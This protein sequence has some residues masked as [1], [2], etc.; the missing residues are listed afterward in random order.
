[1]TAVPP[2]SESQRGTP[3]GAGDF[4]LDPPAPPPGTLLRPLADELLAGAV[5]EES[6]TS[7]GYGALLRSRL[8]LLIWAAQLLSQSAQNVVNYALVV[9]VERLTQ[10]SASVGAVV[11]AFSLPVLLLGPSAGV[12]VD[13]VGKRGVLLWTNILRGLLMAGYLVLPQSLLAIYTVT[14][15]ASVISQFFAPAEGA[16]LPLLV[17]RRALITATSLF[18]LTFTGAQIAGF[19]LVGPT[20]Y[21][22]LGPAALFIAVVVMYALAALCVSLLPRGETTSGGVRDALSRALQLRL[23]WG[24]MREARRFLQGTPGITQAMVHLALAS[25][26]LMTLATL[27][28]GFVARVLGLG[29]EDAGYILA[30][31]GLGM[32]LTTALIGQYAVTADRAKLASRGLVA[33]GVSLALLALVRPV[34][35]AFTAELARGGPGAIPTVETIGYLGL[36]CVVTFSMGVEFSF[37]TIPAQTMIAEATEPHLRGRVFALLFMITGS[38][39]T[40]PALMIGWLADTLGIIPMLLCLASIVAAAGI[41]PLAG[42]GRPPAATRAAP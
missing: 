13:R 21:K 9:E 29:P 38:V 39:S 34:F 37:V 27:G 41:W 5:T 35:E 19:I 22:L 26:L 6:V 28:P 3:A 8:F 2:L 18:N 20:L 33:M 17:K 1:M 15:V 7:G 42:A 30:P 32:I 14:F 16:I 11:V 31:A 4:P 12:F 24:D 36:V 40:V 23:V 25:A 10:S